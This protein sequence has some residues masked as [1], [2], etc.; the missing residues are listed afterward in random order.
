MAAETDKDIRKLESELLQ[1][2]PLTRA[3]LAK[4]LLASLDSLTD[5]EYEQLWA[6]EA[7]ARYDDFLAG[8][9]TAI[10]GDEVFAKARARSR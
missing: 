7:E 4:T 10:D 9:T 3:A 5:E 6:E 2:E 8:R 1:L